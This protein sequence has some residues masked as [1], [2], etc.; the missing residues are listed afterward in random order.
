MKG[1]IPKCLEEMVRARHGQETWDRVKA[2]AGLARW[3]TFLTTEAVSDQMVTDL[4]G[5]A[6]KTLGM[7][8]QQV[9]DDFGMHWSTV[10]APDIYGVY[11]RRA[12]NAREML[13]SMSEV[14]RVTTG[15]VP[16]SAPPR[17]DYEWLDEDT[18]RM[19][20]RSERGLA[21]LMPGLIRGVGAHFR[22]RLEVERRG[23][24]MIVR[25]LGEA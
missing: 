10:Y 3:H 24:D 8:L 20:Y 25:F 16:N 1:T 5:T 11:F 4:F 21:A 2:A 6:A 9:M 7:P 18:L 13:L 19:T 22:E 14:H 17:F 12:S 23:D 15:K